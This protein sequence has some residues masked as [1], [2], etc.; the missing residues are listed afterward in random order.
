MHVLYETDR[1]I[2]YR[3]KH[4]LIIRKYPVHVHVTQYLPAEV[5]CV[6]I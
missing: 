1:H 3:N 4:T 2:A 5:D 6:I